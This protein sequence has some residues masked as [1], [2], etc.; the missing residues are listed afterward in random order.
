[1]TEKELRLEIVRR[2]LLDVE[3]NA[4]SILEAA[5]AI[6]YVRWNFQKALEAAVA[7]RDAT[8]KIIRTTHSPEEIEESER[9]V[10]ES[11][12]EELRIGMMTKVTESP[13]RFA[14]WFQRRI[15]SPLFAEE[16]RVL[17][18][19]DLPMIRSV[20][21]V[22]GY[23]ERSGSMFRFKSWETVSFPGAKN[24]PPRVEPSPDEIAPPAKRLE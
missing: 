21:T 11:S 5:D 9:V 3:E 18:F 10:L 8:A 24:V 20:G 12:V 1:M 16:S 15:V 17:C 23:V 13:A 22:R 14:E 19:S 4:S 7:E 2:Y 6:S